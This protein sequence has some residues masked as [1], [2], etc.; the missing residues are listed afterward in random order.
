M[1][2][3]FA[4]FVFNAMKPYLCTIH[5]FIH[6][7]LT[8]HL[9]TRQG[10]LIPNTTACLGS[11]CIHAVFHLHQSADHYDGYNTIISDIPISKG[12]ACMQPIHDSLTGKDNYKRNVITWACR[13][14]TNAYQLWQVCEDVS[15]EVRAR[16]VQRG[17]CA[18]V[19]PCMPA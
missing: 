1:S 15:R 16:W 5:P 6:Y 10:M 8:R 3:A 7:L 19:W 2:M 14:E 18:C 9:S 11:L 4:F 13:P 17:L 12:D